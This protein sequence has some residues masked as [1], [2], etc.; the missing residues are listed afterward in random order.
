MK[1]SIVTIHG[2]RNYGS[3]LQTYAT[4]EKLR[5]FGLETEVLNYVRED[6]NDANF[7]KWL[8]ERTL[9]N[10]K[11]FIKRIGYSVIIKTSIRKFAKICDTFL[12]ENV[13]M[14]GDRFF[15]FEEIK[16]NSKEADIYCVGS[17]QVWNVN[18]NHGILPAY[19]LE[20]ATRGKRCISYASSFG[21]SQFT[22]SQIE[23]MEP[24]FKNFD[25]LSL[26]ERYGIE[27]LRKM[28]YKA[29]FV[30]DPTLVVDKKFWSKLMD[31]NPIKGKYVLIYQLNTNPKMD[32]YA[33][34]ISKKTGLPLVRI[35][36]RYDHFLRNGK[37]LCFPKVG[38]WLTLFN[39][40][41]YVLTDSFHGLAFSI[42]LSKQFLCFAPKN[43]SDRLIDILRTF[44]L[45]NRMVKD[46]GSLDEIDQPINFGQVD[47]K[48]SQYRQDTQNYLSKALGIE[49]GV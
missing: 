33:Q 39:E 17:D 29:E 20:H 10:S 31:P 48:L 37:T 41:E 44:E 40:A 46:Y 32:A 18:A 28:G 45:E 24:F 34:K 14:S 6:S 43:F 5:E 38:E 4:Q 9:G 47:R 8:I 1:I 13:K 16:A 15:H 26:R 22:N 2:Y 3:V 27:L 12:S 23:E 30:L 11:N 36:T 7:T 49:E 21:T 35:G 25:Y 42:N 19:Y